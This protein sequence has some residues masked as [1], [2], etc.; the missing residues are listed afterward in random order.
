ML[1]SSRDNDRKCQANQKQYNAAVQIYCILYPDKLL[2][3]YI[4]LINK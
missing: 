3:K 2:N 4:N 1:I